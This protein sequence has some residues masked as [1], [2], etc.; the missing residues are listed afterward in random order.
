MLDPL[1]PADCTFFFHSFL[2]DI[3]TSASIPLIKKGH[4]SEVKYNRRFLWNH[5]YM[6]TSGHYLL[7]KQAFPIPPSAE[8]FGYTGGKFSL[9]TWRELN[10]CRTSMTSRV[11]IH[12]RVTRP[13]RMQMLVPSSSRLHSFSFPFVPA[14]KVFSAFH[15]PLKKVME[16]R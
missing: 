13:A 14:E 8:S 6:I 1:P 7:K 10:S 9:Y 11:G 3:G 5:S 12:P 2:A 16:A 4:G 15:S